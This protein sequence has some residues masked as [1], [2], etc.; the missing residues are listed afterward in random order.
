MTAAISTYEKMLAS[1]CEPRSVFG[2]R[3]IFLSALR[4]HWA[5]EANHGELADLV[6]C[7]AYD[8]DNPDAGN[9]AVE[10]AASSNPVPERPSIYIKLLASPL[11]PAG[12]GNLG[13]ISE[14]RAA[15]TYN[16]KRQASLAFRHE[17]EDPDIAT[18]AA[19]SSETFLIGFLKGAEAR[20]LDCHF[21]FLGIYEPE[22][23][24]PTPLRRYGVDVRLDVSF[25]WGVRITPESHLIREIVSSTTTHL[26]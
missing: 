24:R 18:A 9:L 12:I 8:L 26:T 23:V 21:N 10:L 14:D 11:T 25:T 7:Y 6:G 15:R 1:S 4:L 3:K 16:W 20:F 19:E 2:F 22:T 13:D 5:K 17:F